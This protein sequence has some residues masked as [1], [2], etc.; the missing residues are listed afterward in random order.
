[1][2]VNVVENKY[3]YKTGAASPLFCSVSYDPLSFICLY[4]IYE[5]HNCSVT[6]CRVLY[7][8]ILIEVS[9]DYS[10]MGCGTTYFGR[11]LPTVVS[12]VTWR[13]CIILEN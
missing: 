8:Y 4:H 9:Q 1:M 6:N 12:P 5:S 2:C 11:N 7:T 3:K 13:Q 10:L